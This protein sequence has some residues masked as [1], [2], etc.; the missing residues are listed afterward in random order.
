MIIGK[1]AFVI[2]TWNSEAYIRACLD[3]VLSLETKDGL[4]LYIA[5]NGSSDQ[6]VGI[7]REYEE[8]HK[9]FISLNLLSENKG[10]TK[11]RNNALRSISPDTKW[12]CILDS[13]TEVNQNAMEKLIQALEENRN[14]MLTSPRMWRR[15]GEEQLSCKRFPTVFGK[16][17]K[18]VPVRAL[19]NKA[20]KKEGYSFFPASNASGMP[21]V[22]PDAGIYPVDYAISACWMLRADVVKNVGLLDEY[23]LY[24]PEDVDYC[25]A[26]WAKGYEVLFVS[27]ASIYH[28]TQRLSHKKRFSKINQAHISGLVHYFRKYKYWNHPKIRKTIDPESNR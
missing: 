17:R 26:I 18:A 3:S 16:I 9:E 1:V 28:D 2:L 25:A 8:N 13:D 11:P 21:P 20:S 23:Y 6:T 10:T 24:A 4:H 12:V 15:N 22:A 7:L 5:D 27:A 14:A 19:Q